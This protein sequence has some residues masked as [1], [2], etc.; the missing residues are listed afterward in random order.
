MPG[1]STFSKMPTEKL[2]T[3]GE[4]VANELVL[5]GE[6]TAFLYYKKD[7]FHAG[8]HGPITTVAHEVC[9]RWETDENFHIDCTPV[10]LVKLPA[11]PNL[12]EIT[13]IDAKAWCT[14]WLPVFLGSFPGYND[15]SKKPS[16]YPI[17][18]SPKR[19]K[20][21]NKLDCIRII[22]AMY[23]HFEGLDV[24]Y[25]GTAS[26]EAGIASLQLEQLHNP[27]YAMKGM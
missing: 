24:P 18:W 21:K 12:L 25:A 10:R 8:G 7:N 20:N 5:R 9:V 17:E 6:Q 2:K 13:Q 4:L 14:T 26:V 23:K 15:P 22:A 1:L 11:P 19:N 3:I 16:W 27:L